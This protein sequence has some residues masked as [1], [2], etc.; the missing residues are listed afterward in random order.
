MRRDKNRTRRAARRIRRRLMYRSH[1]ARLIKTAKIT[2]CKDEP[3]VHSEPTPLFLPGHSEAAAGQ[4]FNPDIA[5]G[6]I[7]FFIPM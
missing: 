5:F 6:F 1:V 4:P 2:N 7:V 3:A